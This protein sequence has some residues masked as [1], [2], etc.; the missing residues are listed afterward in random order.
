MVVNFHKGIGTIENL[1]GGRPVQVAQASTVAIVFTA[2]DADNTKFPLNEPLALIGGSELLADMVTTGTGPDAFAQMFAEGTGINCIGVRVE[3]GADLAATMANVVG[4]AGPQTGVHAIRAA[5]SELGLTPRLMLAPGFTS[6]RIDNGANPAVSEMLG[7][8]T[9]R[10]GMIIADGPN[11]TKEAAL[12]YREDWGSSRVYMVDPAVKRFVGGQTVVQPASPSVVGLTLRVDNTLGVNHSPSNH[13]FLGI[14][15][16][17]RPIDY[18]DGDNATEAD[19][20]TRNQIAT[21]IRD[22]GYRLWGNETTWTEPLNKFFPVVR[23]HDIIMDS[24]AQAHRWAR[25]KPFST[26]LILDIAETVNGF[27]RSMKASG[28]TIGYEVWIDPALNTQT[29]WLNGDLYVSYDGEAPA[30]LQRLIFQFNRNTNYYAEL[31]K[32]AM[33]EVARLA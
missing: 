32:E 5:Q 14:T 16:V 28:W 25:D 23:V 30:P 8:A 27:L 11:T 2:P 18:A 17:A 33:G 9:S 10:R 13:N 26:Q 24:V 20:L 15:G 19:Y 29:T 12:Q 31:A 3:E 6:Q 1:K 4:A 7:I 22:G 21:I